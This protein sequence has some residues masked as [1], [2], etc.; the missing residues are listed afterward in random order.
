[1]VNI[2]ARFYVVMPLVGRKNCQIQC[3]SSNIPYLV[4][5]QQVNDL[6]C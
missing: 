4:L 5:D 1:M 3:Q 6:G 2:H